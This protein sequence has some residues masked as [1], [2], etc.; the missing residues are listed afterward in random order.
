MN[1]SPLA[2]L[3]WQESTIIF[4]L[5]HKLSPFFLSKLIKR[6]IH[7]YPRDTGKH[8]FVFLSMPPEPFGYVRRNRVNDLSK[9][10]QDSSFR[11]IVPH[12]DDISDF[13]RKGKRLL[14][15]ADLVQRQVFD[16]HSHLTMQQYSN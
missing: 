10:H 3:L 8:R 1:L 11:E 14:I 15:G 13:I 2:V 9:L 4:P 12:N 7:Q 16:S 6:L 5:L